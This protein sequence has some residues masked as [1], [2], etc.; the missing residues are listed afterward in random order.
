[1]RRRR[2][3]PWTIDSDDPRSGALHHAEAMP[4]IDPV[5]HWRSLSPKDD[6]TDR[7]RSGTRM[8]M[9]VLAPAFL[10][11]ICSIRRLFGW[12]PIRVSHVP[13]PDTFDL[14]DP[15]TNTGPFDTLRSTS[16]R[17]RLNGHG[18][19]TVGRNSGSTFERIPSPHHLRN[20]PSWS[21]AALETVPY[22]GQENYEDT[23]NGFEDDSADDQDRGRDAGNGVILISRDGDDF[24]L[25]GSAISVP[26]GRRSI[27]VDRRS[28]EVVPP[29]PTT[30]SKKVS[31]LYGDDDPCVTCDHL[32][33]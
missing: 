15:V 21:S 26:I 2:Q 22:N 1:M 32:T 3:A 18:P 30:I 29:S 33:S 16:S 20:K 12:G 23:G 4:M 7:K 24:S 25:S 13:V 9:G 14:E 19:P 10:K 5:L 28:I 8:G 31:I 11:G 27:E 6:A 17:S